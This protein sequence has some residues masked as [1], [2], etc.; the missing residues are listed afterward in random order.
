MRLEFKA[1]KCS[2]ASF[3]KVVQLPLFSDKGHTAELD[4]DKGIIEVEMIRRRRNE[5]VV[6]LTRHPKF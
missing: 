5:F 6:S 4:R 2:R 1:R 3:V